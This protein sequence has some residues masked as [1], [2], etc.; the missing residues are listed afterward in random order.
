MKKIIRFIFKALEYLP[1]AGTSIRVANF[2]SKI[3]NLEK[4]HNFKE[5]RKVRSEALKIIPKS[6]Q[7]PLLRSEGEDRLYRLKDYKGALTAFEQAI[8][9]MEQS[10][11][12]YGVSSPDRIYGG[13]AQ[14]ALLNKEDDKAIQHYHEFAKIV[15]EF[16]KNK[17]LENAL[18]W[19]RETLK[20]LE[21]NLKKQKMANPKMK[22][23]D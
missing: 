10:P 17:E 20:Y 15:E 4:G 16:S 19:H 3:G 5:A 13:A 2:N 8:V 9:S 23:D 14:A 12:L 11:S 21:T 18:K 6:H 22:A 1:W 7:G